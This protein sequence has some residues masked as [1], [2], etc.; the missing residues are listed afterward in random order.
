[1]ELF[2]KSTIDDVPPQALFK[3][4]SSYPASGRDLAMYAPTK[5][6]AADLQRTM[7][8]A[9]KPLLN[10]VEVFDEYRGEHVPEGQRSL[11]FR[12][13]YRSSDRTLTDAEVDPVHQA[14]RDAVLEKYGV[15][16]R[17]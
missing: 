17:S 4:Y 11:A 13:L 5:L 12:L 15:N 1:L 10:S 9:G 14:V 2:L 8:K 16:L 7:L 6:A 3:P